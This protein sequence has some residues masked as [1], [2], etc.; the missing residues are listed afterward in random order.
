M[1]LEL[2]SLSLRSAERYERVYAIEVAPIVLGGTRH[3]VLI[4]DDV[5]VSVDRVAGGFLV[6][7]DAEAKLY[8]PCARC[9]NEAV[10]EV[11]VE[12]QEFAPTAKSGWEETELSAFIKDLVVDLSALVREAVVLALPAQVVCSP[13]CKGLCPQCGRDLNKGRCDCTTVEIDERWSR[14]KDLTFD[15]AGDS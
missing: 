14:L 5:T 7:I 4:P 11:H 3:D 9:L 1:Y 13:E 2:E 12:Q 6:N 8:G 15:D 10:L